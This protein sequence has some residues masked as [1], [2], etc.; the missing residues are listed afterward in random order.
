MDIMTIWNGLVK[1][2]K[3]LLSIWKKLPLETKV[4]IINIVIAF[5]KPILEKYYDSK[6]Q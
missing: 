5:W 4:K 2:F 3:L 1:I 6:R